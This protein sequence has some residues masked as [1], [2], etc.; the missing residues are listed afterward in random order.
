MLRM[1]GDLPTEDGAALAHGV[2]HRGDALQ[3]FL[4]LPAVHAEERLAEPHDQAARSP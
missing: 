2:S 3:V 4:L 1:P